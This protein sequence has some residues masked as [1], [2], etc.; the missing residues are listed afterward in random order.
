MNII[1]ITQQK[2]KNS[3]QH[4][5]A[6]LYDPGSGVGVVA[7][8]CTKQSGVYTMMDPSQEQSAILWNTAN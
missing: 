1:N 5:I 8:G 4:W 6:C 3:I 2:D 7:N